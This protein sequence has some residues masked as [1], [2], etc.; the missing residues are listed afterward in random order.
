MSLDLAF[1]REQGYQVCRGVLTAAEIQT[2]ANFLNQACLES[3]EQLQNHL[4]LPDMRALGDFLAACEQDPA[5]FSALPG[6]LRQILVGHFE[7]E[8][9]LNPV[10]WTIPRSAGIQQLLAA[11]F[12]GQ[13]VQMHM[14]PTARFVLPGHRWSGVPPHQDIA[15]NRHM[16]DFMTIWVPLV[17]IDTQCGGVIVHAGTGALAEQPLQ[18][19]E[20]SKSP[21]FWQSGVAD[22]RGAKIQPEFEPGDVLL[23]NRWIVHESA[24]NH[25]DRTRL[26]VDCRFFT[27]TSQK[28]ALDLQHWHVIEPALC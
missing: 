21:L 19:P 7:L 13:F 28:H 17:P 25:S 5:R 24:P 6:E 20:P 26:S 18:S 4:N 22:L 2:L 16:Q 10:L 11:V 9:R 23:L 1:F 8:T 14:P 15:Y 27:G 3:C 12:P